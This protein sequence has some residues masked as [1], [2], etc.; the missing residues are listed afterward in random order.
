MERYYAH[1]KL[2][3][4]YVDRYSVDGLLK[5]WPTPPYRWWYLGDWAAPEGVNVQDPASVDLVSNCVMVQNYLALEKMALVMGLKAD[6]VE[7]RQR[8]EALRSKIHETFYHKGIYASGS[9]ID[10]VYP[11]LVGVVP[12]ELEQQVVKTLKERTETLYN[13]HLATGLVGI[14]VL[15][16]WATRTGECDW[17]YGMLKQHGY[18][19]YLYMLD[20]GATGVWEHWNGERSRF[21]NCY[22]GIGSWFYEALGGIV[23]LEPGY[24]R[25][26]IAPQIP[27]GLDWVKVTRP[28]PYGPITVER[29]GTEVHYTVPVG[30]TVEINEDEYE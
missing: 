20:N 5:E 19:G 6:A 4:E 3:L 17:L 25:V 10:L 1:M 23:A 27:A 18:P 24:R 30:V 14:P 9:Q 13:G 12:P 22:N 15:T 28:T 11:L 8:L 7:Y 16:E 21:H 26:R 29:K 2:W